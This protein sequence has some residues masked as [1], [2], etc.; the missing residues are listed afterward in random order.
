MKIENLKRKIN[1]SYLELWAGA[2]DKDSYH[3]HVHIHHP[4][5]N[6]RDQRYI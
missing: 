6:P 4:S 5:D 1:S 2:G 3:S